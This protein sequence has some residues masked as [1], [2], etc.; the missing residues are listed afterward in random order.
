[1]DTEFCR[2]AGMTFA[3]C[4]SGGGIGGRT[5]VCDGFCCSG[6]GAEMVTDLARGLDM[7]VGGRVVAF[8]LVCRVR[9]VITGFWIGLG[10]ALMGRGM[11]SSSSVIES[12]SL[13]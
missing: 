9:G 5:R 8:R 12:T 13:A 10:G 3:D 2:F 11:G 4:E 6:W 1:M 7:G